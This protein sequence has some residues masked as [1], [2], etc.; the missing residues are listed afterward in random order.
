MLMSHQTYSEIGIYSFFYKDGKL[1]PDE[2]IYFPLLAGKSIFTGKTCLPGDDSG[3][4]IS[5]KNRYYSE[6]TGIYWVWKNTRHNIV[7]SCHY[8]RFFTSRPEPLAYRLKR[9]FY[10]V[11]GLHR[12]RHGLIYTCCFNR[13]RER[14]LNENEIRGILAEYDVILPQKRRL[15]YSVEKHY[16]RYH[17]GNDLLIVRKIIAAKHPGYLAAFEETL[18]QKELYANNMF[19]MKQDDFNCFMEWWFDILFEFEKTVVLE[20]YKGYQQRIFGF[21]AERLLTVWFRKNKLTIKELPVIY[22]KRLKYE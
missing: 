20:N 8:R 4:N 18:Q 5:L 7:G 17:D 12:K 9:L 16:Q 14:I 10:Y 6:L 22:F 2:K 3:D 15:R 13:F 11:A 1:V 21:M 19:V